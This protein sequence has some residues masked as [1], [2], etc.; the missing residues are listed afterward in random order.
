MD[1]P[2]QTPRY[3]YRPPGKNMGGCSAGEPRTVCDAN[4]LVCHFFDKSTKD[5][6]FRDSCESKS[7]KSRLCE[8]GCLIFHYLVGI[9]LQFHI[10]TLSLC[11]ISP[12][13]P[14]PGFILF[15]EQETV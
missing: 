9:E 13:P 4:D 6:S 7:W 15:T 3:T 2:P 1:A 10:L 8:V 12:T 14:Y 5:I 11:H